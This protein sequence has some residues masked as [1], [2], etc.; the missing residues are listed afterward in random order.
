MLKP[1]DQLSGAALDWAVGKANGW[2][3][4]PSDSIEHGRWYHITP[5]IAPK[6]HEHNRL[7]VPDY[8]PSRNWCQGGPIIERE[9]ISFRKYHNP[10]SEAHGTYWAKVCRESG[11]MVRW[12]K[13]SAFS[14]PTP[15]IAAMRLYVASKLG[16][17][18]DIPG[19]LC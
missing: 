5:S 8:Q 2:I 15:L 18:I 17:E 13:K 3:T 9:D 6:G 12:S 1:I 16:H 10:K 7:F 19:E 14:G 4:Y 11:S